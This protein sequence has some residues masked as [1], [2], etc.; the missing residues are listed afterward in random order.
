[1]NFKVANNIEKLKILHSIIKRYSSQFSNNSFDVVVVGGG[2]IGCATAR[3]LLIE[4]RNLRVGLVEKENKLSFH[5][6][7]H[8]SGVIHAG[9]YYKPGSLR[10]K[11]CIK[12]LQMTYDYC[13][14]KNIPYKKC[15]K[16]IVATNENEIKRLIDLYERGM[17]NSTPDIKLLDEHEI[18]TIEPHCKGL[19]AIYSPHTGI[20]DWATVTQNYAADFKHMGGKIFY[21]FKVESFNENK[22]GRALKL[23]AK[24]NEVVITDY[25]ITCGGLQSD[26]L[27]IMTGCKDEPYILPVRGE[28][29]LLKSD[30]SYLVK[31]NI[32]PVP[33]PDLPFL[34]VHFTPR[35]DGSVFLGPNAVLALKQEGY[36][37]NDI[38]IGNTLR[39]L[40]KKGVRKLL[41]NNIQFGIN[42][43]LKSIYLSKQLR[44]LQNYIP[45]IQLN[46][47][48]RGPSGVRAQPLWSNGKMVED[49]VLDCASN[50]PNE[51]VK[52]R[53]LHCRSAPSPSATSSL[54]IA[55]IIV[56]KMF[57]KYPKLKL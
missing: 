36:K 25:V 12:G 21:D 47:I 38:S 44:E 4:N 14:K 46:D 26:K 27:S 40:K 7:G 29:L 39:V 48:I 32:Y 23:R 16:L 52:Y 3:A 5:Q 41:K 2:I 15:G 34:G 11:L 19:N 51:S 24:N 53:V 6:S 13:N 43:I 28:Y 8:N 54:P 55:D 42:E 33:N 57:K 10:A 37:W 18:K 1:M 20:V 30:K 49:L 9:I 31:G 17:Q 50:D 45:N 22:N 35:M 56:D